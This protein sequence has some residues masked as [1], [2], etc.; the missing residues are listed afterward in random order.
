MPSLTNLSYRQYLD[1]LN[2]KKVTTTQKF[3]ITLFALLLIVLG[4]SSTFLY[5]E[6]KKD[7]PIRAQNN[8]LQ[9]L[10]ANFNANKQSLEDILISYQVAGTKTQKTRDPQSAT[11]EAQAY[12]VSLEDINKLTQ[13]VEAA[14]KNTKSQLDTL[15]KT[16]PPKGFEQ[17][18]ADV[19]AYFEQSVALFETIES[20]HTFTKEVVYILGTKYFA[21]KLTDEKIWEKDKKDDVYTYYETTKTD[22]Q[23]IAG[24]LKAL[25]PPEDFKA[26]QKDQIA[27]FER[28]SKLSDDI[29]Q[30]LKTKEE[31]SQSATQ[32]EK[33]YQLLITAQRETE[34]LQAGLEVY[35]LSLFDQKRNYDKFAKVKITQNSL[36]AR[37]YEAASKQPP[38]YELKLPNIKLP[39]I[40][41]QFT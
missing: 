40:F 3:L 33:A 12:S 23:I 17:L 18:T 26:Y 27:Y 14:K 16:S 20:E 22:S 34:K 35:K 8:Y 37:I 15:R 7:A 30:A 9:S 11:K 41:K 31:T 13:K 5:Q 6:Y 39:Q 25:N 2:K 21:P 36:D 1:F 10:Y 32:M 29:L 28:L 4:I 19:R 24:K 38:I